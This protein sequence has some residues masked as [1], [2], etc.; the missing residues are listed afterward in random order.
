VQEGTE[1]L[2]VRREVAAG[3][4]AS[5]GRRGGWSLRGAVV[6]GFTALGDLL[7]VLE[8]CRIAPSS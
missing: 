6:E 3:K 1:S 2:T 4:A 5:L 8:T 7:V